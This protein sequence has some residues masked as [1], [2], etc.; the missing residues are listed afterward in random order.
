MTRRWTFGSKRMPIV[1]QHITTSLDMGGAQTMLV[2]L[3]EAGAGKDRCSSVL[4]LMQP[5][6]LTPLLQEAG[7]PVY[8]L[9]MR[10]GM[11]GPLALVRLLRITASVS[12]DLIQ[13]W[14]YHGN[15]AAS[16]AGFIQGANVPVIWNV[17]HSLTNPAVEKRATRGL[18]ALSARLS[19][20][21]A[22]IIYNSQAAALEHE[23]IGFAAD[24]ATY[25]PNGF[26]CERFRPDRSRGAHLRT[27]FG[28]EDDALVVAMV[29]RLHPMKDHRTLVDAVAQA[30]ATGSKLHLLLVGTGL[31]NPPASLTKAISELLPPNSVT[32]VG[33]RTDVAD[34]LPG[35][36]ILALSSAWGEAFPNVLGE[37]MACGIPCVATDVG[38]CAAILG[39]T[40]TIV[41]PRDATA[42]A[43]ALSHIVALGSNG[44]ERLGH[45]ARTR[46]SEHFEI[47]QI[48]LRYRRLYAS[49]L[50]RTF[51][52]TTDW[53]G[54]IT[55]AVGARPA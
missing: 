13:G 41:P 28:I 23:A 9:G 33:E 49:V 5:G 14:M 18:L 21:A 11:I 1:T 10:R 36:D 34:W 31:D 37:A 7:C 27:L 25:I 48:A 47:G 15:L 50:D 40:G 44:R 51:A 19:G 39:D 35:V 52:P 30:R 45:A 20:S 8:S 22:A 17:R 42:L 46:V 2:K 26:D 3:L 24:R 16:V 4:S 43:A 53:K 29:A 32:L 54:S 6:V 55:T 38:D 12:P